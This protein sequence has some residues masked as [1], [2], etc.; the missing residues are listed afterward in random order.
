MTRLQL[1]GGQDYW[2]SKALSRDDIIKTNIERVSLACLCYI[3]PE[4]NLRPTISRP[5]CLGVRPLSGTRDQFFLLLEISFRQLQVYYFVAHSLTRGRVYNL[6]YN[7]LSSF[8]K[9]CKGGI[10]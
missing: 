7:C 1:F 5:V 10:S 4:V 2:K 6:I 8:G 3:E 9:V